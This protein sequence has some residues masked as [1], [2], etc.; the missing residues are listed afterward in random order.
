M[1]MAI[2]LFGATEKQ[3]RDGKNREFLGGRRRNFIEG[4][5]N[6]LEF[7]SEFDQFC[8]LSNVQLQNLNVLSISEQIE[9]AP[10][11]CFSVG[12]PSTIRFPKKYCSS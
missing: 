1:A 2:L 11:C 3:L 6:S 8:D 9:T 12:Y 4:A 5:V 7:I 10:C